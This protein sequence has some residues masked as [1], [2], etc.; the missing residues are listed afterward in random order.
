MVRTI[1]N[2]T[3]AK[4]RGSQMGVGLL[5]GNVLKFRIEN[6]F[7]SFWA[8]VN[9]HDSATE[10][11]SENVSVFF[12]IFFKKLVWLHSINDGG[13]KPGKPVENYWST[14]GIFEKNLLKHIDDYRNQHERNQNK[15]NKLIKRKTQNRLNYRRVQSRQI[16]RTKK[17]HY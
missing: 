3:F 9:G 14:I 7:M 12:L 1:V 16:N 4:N 8:Q 17:A 10:N 15:W 5:S 11:K 13:T 2:D 6:K